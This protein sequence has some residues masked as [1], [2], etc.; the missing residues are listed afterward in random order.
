MYVRLAFAVAAHLEPE[1]LIV[2]EVLAVGDVE[3]QKKCLGKMQDVSSRE[4]RTV[5]FVSHNMEAM[6]SL[7]TR[8]LLLR[9]GRVVEIGSPGEVI[10]RY[11]CDERPVQGQA[12]FERKQDSAVQLV[13]LCVTQCGKVPAALDARKPFSI[14][15]TYEVLSAVEHLELGIR[16]YNSRGVPITTAN[17][18]EGLDVQPMTLIA[19]T[20]EARVSVPALF[21]MPDDYT[22][23]AAAYQ[24]NRKVLDQRDHALQFRMLELGTSVAKYGRS[25]DIGVVLN[26]FPWT[27]KQIPR[28]GEGLVTP[29]TEPICLI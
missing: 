6:R 24:F 12:I 19:G 27:H 9:D 18:S 20:Y 7:C 15:L 5:L 14:D 4:G 25:A 22:L 13:S 16:I 1:V 26:H 2:D 17:S 10:S 28:D 29:T 8:A 21:L 23:T 3:F 11:L